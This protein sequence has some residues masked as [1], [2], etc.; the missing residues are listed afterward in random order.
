MKFAQ[1]KHEIYML[2]DTIKGVLDYKT[3]FHFDL[4]KWLALIEYE[5]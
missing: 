5:E 3:G 1:F 2:D 4:E